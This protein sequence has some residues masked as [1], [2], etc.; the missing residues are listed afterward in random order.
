MK[1]KSRATGLTEF[2]SHV[3]A[4]IWRHQPTTA[5][6]VRHA[7]A[8]SPTLD[9]ALSQGSVYPVIERLKARDLVRAT[10]L[11]DKRGTEHLSCTTPGEHAVR[12]WLADLPARLPDDPLR[13]RILA[14]A[15]LT[16][17][18]R[19]AWVRKAKDCLLQDLAQVE[20]FAESNP[21]ALL[22]LA[23]DN[24]RSTLLA[25]IRWLERVEAKIGFLEI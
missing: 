11:Q 10:A 9:F 1:R 6:Q 23:H 3:L 13:S 17:D 20:E 18:E 5:Y 2:E 14:L 4:L 7:H 12:A 8:R 21:G 24:A 22:D 15:I 25:R 19:V 16:K